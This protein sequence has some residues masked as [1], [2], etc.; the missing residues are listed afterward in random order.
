LQSF[1]CSPDSL[2]IRTVSIHRE[3]IDRTQ[4]KTHDWRLKKFCH[5]QPVDFPS[6]Q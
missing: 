6:K 5:R 3:R 1:N 2:A 4:K